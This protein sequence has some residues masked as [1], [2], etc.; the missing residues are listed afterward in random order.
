MA[1]IEVI[2]K[3]A[4]EAFAS[5]KSCAV[6]DSLR[7]SGL[8]HLPYVMVMYNAQDGKTWYH[9]AI[10]PDKR[11][12]FAADLVVASGSRMCG[13]GRDLVGAGERFLRRLGFD[14]ISV[15][16][17]KPEAIGFWGKMGYQNING[18]LVKRLQ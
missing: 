8:R 7:V 12:L 4:Y 6:G 9:F 15:P 1:D 14:E 11:E 17:P 18:S 2:R 10:E 16:D 13:I 5:A 3:E